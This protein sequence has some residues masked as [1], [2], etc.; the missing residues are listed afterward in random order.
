MNISSVEILVS[1]LDLEEAQLKKSR[2]DGTYV[3]ESEIS[4]DDDVAE[5]SSKPLVKKDHTGKKE[6]WLDWGP[7]GL[8]RPF[9]LFKGPPLK[10]KCEPQKMEILKCLGLMTIKRKKEIELDKFLRRQQHLKEPLPL[11]MIEDQE[12]Q[13]PIPTSLLVSPLSFRPTSS[14][15]SL[16]KK[17]TMENGKSKWQQKNFMEALELKVNSHDELQEGKIFLL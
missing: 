11:K 14:L 16:T 13:R 15:N 2:M 9:I 17:V 6:P 7:R 3:S 1:K 10:P 12:N 5:G 8:K 4:D